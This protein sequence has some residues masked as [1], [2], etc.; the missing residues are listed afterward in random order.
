MSGPLAQQLDIVTTT[1]LARD[2]RLLLQAYAAASQAGTSGSRR[3]SLARALEVRSYLIRKGLKSTRIDVRALGTSAASG[4]A[5]RVDI[6]LL[7]R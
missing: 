7:T 2:E 1:M 5:D 6:I 4:P 3:L